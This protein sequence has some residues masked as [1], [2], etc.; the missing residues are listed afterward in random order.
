MSILI[1]D[2]TRVICQ[3]ITG[4]QGTFHSERA[5]A[6]GTQIVGGVRQGKGGAMHLGVPVFDTVAEAMGETRAK[7]RTNSAKLWK[8]LCTKHETPGETLNETVDETQGETLA[9]LWTKQQRYS[10]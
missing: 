1:D 9:K 7:L 4:R 3:G 2:S 5:L 8:T 6:S 10:G